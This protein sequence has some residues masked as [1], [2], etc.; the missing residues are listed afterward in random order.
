M[1]LPQRPGHLLLPGV[2]VKTYIPQKPAATTEDGGSDAADQA[3]GLAPHREQ[4]PSE[5]DYLNHGETVL[6]LP[7]LRKTTV[8][9]DPAAASS[10]NSGN[11]AAANPATGGSWLIDSERRRGEVGSC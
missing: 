10:N 7:D 11:A 4:I 1:L 9:L 6:V 8:C 3:R 2:E 5:V